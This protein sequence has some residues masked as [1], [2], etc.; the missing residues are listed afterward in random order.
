MPPLPAA[1]RAWCTAQMREVLGTAARTIAEV[2][3]VLIREAPATAHLGLVKRKARAAGRV[4]RLRDL[5]FKYMP[6]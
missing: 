5:Q 1:T 3:A 4:L 2:G 6:R